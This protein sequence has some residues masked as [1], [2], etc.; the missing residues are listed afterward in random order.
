MEVSV[1]NLEGSRACLEVEADE[2]AVAAAFD[3][4]FKEISRT[5]PMPGFRKGKAPREWIARVVGEEVV[6]EQAR[7]FLVEETFTKAVEEQELTVLGEADFDYPEEDMKD[8]EKF[9]YKATFVIKPK[10]D[11]PEYK[12]LEVE[13]ETRSA[14]DELVD[15]EIEGL[16]MRHSKIVPVGDRPIQEGDFVDLDYYVYAQ[17]DAAP[18]ERERRPMALHIGENWFSPS[19]DD[20]VVGLSKGD[21]KVIARR[22]SDDHPEQAMAGRRL[23]F[24]VVVKQV[25]ERQVP[26]IDDEF[27]MRVTGDESIDEMRETIKDRIQDRLDDLTQQSVDD[28]LMARLVIEC[29]FEVPP[30]L[31]DVGVHRRM[32]TWL[33]VMREQGVDPAARLAASGRTVQDLESGFRPDARSGARRALIIDAIAEAEGITADEEE[34][35]QEVIKIAA[36]AGTAPEVVRRQLEENN[37]LGEIE[38]RIRTKTVM[39][40]LRE[41]SEIVEV[42][43]LSGEEQQILE[44]AEEIDAEPEPDPEAEEEAAPEPETEEAAEPETAEETAEDKAEAEEPSDESA[45]DEP[46]D[47]ESSTEPEPETTEEK[48]EE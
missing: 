4:S 2:K 33:D 48:A 38:D 35:T 40:R 32:A 11:L 31:I 30:P 36:E 6:C 21:T 15:E 19:L 41:W 34:V 20:E 29:E 7:D 12:G 9:T 8:G 3:K 42:E 43:E 44:R 13:R 46:A 25:K 17:G 1:E 24:D 47:E 5:V 16:K 18:A 28:R 22:F 39:E 37:A 27:A 45:D 23:F 10:F 26:D 14:T